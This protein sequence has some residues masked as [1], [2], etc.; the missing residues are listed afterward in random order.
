M[1]ISYSRVALTEL[2]QVTQ[3]IHMSFY[4]PQSEDRHD[5]KVKTSQE[6]STR[7]TQDSHPSKIKPHSYSQH[8]G[9]GKC[10]PCLL[11]KELQL[12]M[13]KRGRNNWLSHRNLPHWLL[14]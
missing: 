6:R 1:A 12:G 5:L 9:V 3:L 2:A 11:L 13:E 10:T 8:R 7:D 4:L 14:I